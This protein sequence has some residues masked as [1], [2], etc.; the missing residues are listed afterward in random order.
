MGNSG[1]RTHA[2]RP[3]PEAIPACPGG[4]GGISSL[5][6]PFPC[7]SRNLIESGFRPPG[8]QGFRAPG[9][10]YVTGVTEGGL[11]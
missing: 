9:N 7:I 6:G 10:L 2:G 11:G 8:G 3:D 5:G 4:P 1:F